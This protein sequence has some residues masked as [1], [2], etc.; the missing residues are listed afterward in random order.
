MLKKRKYGKKYY[1]F[2][3]YYFQTRM[4]NR[5]KNS[6]IAKVYTWDVLAT[7]QFWHELIYFEINWKGKGGVL[8]VEIEENEI[9]EDMLWSRKPLWKDQV[10]AHNKWN[11]SVVDVED[12]RTSQLHRI[13]SLIFLIKLKHYWQNRRNTSVQL[14]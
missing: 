7:V 9:W 10:K 12:V 2:I 3:L 14:G 11:V 6:R 8:V 1:Q 5:F 4:Q 13:Q